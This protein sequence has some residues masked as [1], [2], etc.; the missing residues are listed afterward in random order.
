MGLKLCGFVI[1]L[2]DGFGE[3]QIPVANLAPCECVKRV[4]RVVEPVVGEGLVDRFPH[5]GRF[6]DD[7]FVQ[8]LADVW[9]RGVAAVRDLVV[10]G[11]AEGIPQLCPE[12]PIAFDPVLRQFQHAADSRHLGHGKAQGVGPEF[13]HNNE[14][15]HD[16]AAGFR[17][18]F[19]LLVADELVEVDGV[20]RVFTL[21]RLGHHHHAGDPEEQD[22]LAGDED[23][24][25]EVFREFIGL[26]GPAEGAERPETGGEPCV[27]DVI[28]SIDFKLTF[29]IIRFANHRETAPAFR[30]LSCDNFYF[31]GIAALIVGFC[32]RN[33]FGFSWCT[34]KFEAS[35][36]IV[37]RSIVT[38]ELTIPN[39][40]LMPPPKLPRDAP[41]LDVLKP[42]V[43]HLFAAFGHDCHVAVLHRIQSWANDLVR[44][45]EP[46][47]S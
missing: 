25:G 28:I 9:H 30:V 27:E 3:L 4:G 38:P 33:G 11:K 7:P 13:V 20:E 6:T 14:R 1:A 39:R 26:F 2:Q 10:F 32:L 18:L 44:V 45:H 47:V 12:V 21:N 19:T 17:H 16:V 46:L 41:W 15:V 35:V 43:E 22:V 34:E 36:C 40:Y 29:T 5:L 42:V 8:R 31:L 24:A 37:T 23:I